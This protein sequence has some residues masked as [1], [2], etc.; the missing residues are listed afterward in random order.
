MSTVLDEIVANKRLE[1]S[2]LM[3]QIPVSELKDEPFFSR[4]T[5][6]L[7]NS[8]KNSSTG[9]ISEFKRKS[10][11][12]GDIH[13]GIEPKEVVP[14]YEKYGFIQAESEM[15]LIRNQNHH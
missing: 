1:I 10:P 2:E 14:L 9:I 12:K 15:T 5:F 3:K 11:S 4:E 13:Q 8:L 6:S 7:K